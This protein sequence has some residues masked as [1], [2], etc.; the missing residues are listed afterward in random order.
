MAIASGGWEWPIELEDGSVLGV[1]MA[2]AV[3]SVFVGLSGMTAVGVR[4]LSLRVTSKGD[5]QQTSS[6]PEYSVLHGRVATIQMESSPVELE[7]Q[8]GLPAQ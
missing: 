2:F 7:R 4:W 8:Q 3:V 1:Q 6:P 5:K